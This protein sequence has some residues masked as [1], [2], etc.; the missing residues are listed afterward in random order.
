MIEALIKLFA[1]KFD[2]KFNYKPFLHWFTSRTIE[3]INNHYHKTDQ[4]KAFASALCK[5]YVL[6]KL[7]GIRP[8]DICLDY[9]QYGKPYLINHYNIYFNISHTK[10]YL[11]FAVADSELGIDLE[12]IDDNL[13]MNIKDIVFSPQECELIETAK[14]FYTL[15]SKKEAYLKYLGTGFLTDDYKNTNLTL[16]LFQSSHKCKIIT[17]QF[18]QNYILSIAC[19]NSDI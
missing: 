6:P 1:V 14:E 5:Y 10:E 12:Y 15:W 8:I 18:E 3:Q 13:D 16:D 17:N 11:I 9:N 19:N 7:L 4:I 2:D